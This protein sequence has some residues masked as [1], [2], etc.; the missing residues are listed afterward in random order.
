MMTVKT[1]AVLILAYVLALAAGT[2][3]GLLADRLRT[4]AGSA[5]PLAQQ[6]QLTPVQSEQIRAV[7][8]GVSQTVDSCYQQGQ[9]IQNRRDQALLNLLTDD[10]KAKF[11]IID[12]D[13]A[14]QFAEQ[15]TKRQAAFQQGLTETEAMLSPEQRVKYE[16]IVRARLGDLSQSQGGNP[17]VDQVRP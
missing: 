9:A 12:K 14:R 11:A 13:D 7:W 17:A 10:Q 3:S 1:S 5:A 15:M 4:P 16:Q 2:T 6:L 8:E